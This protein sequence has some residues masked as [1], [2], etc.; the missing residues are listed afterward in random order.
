MAEVCLE[1]VKIEL[2]KVTLKS[3]LRVRMWGIFL[4]CLVGSCSKSFC[5]WCGCDGKHRLVTR[6]EDVAM[7]Q[8]GRII[9]VCDLS[10]QHCMSYRECGPSVSRTLL[11]PVPQFTLQTLLQRKLTLNLKFAC[12]FLKKQNQKLL[13]SKLLWRGFYSIL[14]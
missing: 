10:F 7:P 2:S 12:F 13:L 5:P 3:I 6:C 11:K 8:H 14:K 9:Q 1:S 4:F